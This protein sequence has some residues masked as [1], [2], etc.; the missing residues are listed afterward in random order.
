MNTFLQSYMHFFHWIPSPVGLL[1]N[2]DDN[3]A[4][5]EAVKLISKCNWRNKNFMYNGDK[6]GA[7]LETNGAYATAVL[8]V[9]GTMV[10][11]TKLARANGSAL[12]CSVG[13][14]K[15]AG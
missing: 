14:M 4:I 7:A 15:P 8:C 10:L 6:L 9:V 13:T 5:T 3:L 2:E 11:Q 12:L 1:E